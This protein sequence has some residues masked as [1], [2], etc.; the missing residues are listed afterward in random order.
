MSSLRLW[1]AEAVDVQ[2][3]GPLQQVTTLAL[4]ALKSCSALRHVAHH[5]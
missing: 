5:E 1:I 4:K 3:C 2:T